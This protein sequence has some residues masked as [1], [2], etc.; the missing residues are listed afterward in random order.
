MPEERGASS[1][2]AIIII[3]NLPLLNYP[4]HKILLN[5]LKD[6]IQSLIH[7]AIRFN[8]TTI[9]IRYFKKR[10]KNDII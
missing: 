4:F 6:I 1:A 10:N 5:I 2:D 8:Y 7:L 3:L 9:P